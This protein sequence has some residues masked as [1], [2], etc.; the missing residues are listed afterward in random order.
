MSRVLS[1]DNL[2]NTKHKKFGFQGEWGEILGDLPTSSIWLIQGKEKH[3][4]TALALSLTAYLSEYARSLY[5]SGEEGTGSLF[6]DN[7]KRAGLGLHHKRIGFLRYTPINELNSTLKKRYSA[8]S[9]MV[10]NM[11]VYDDEFKRGGVSRFIKAN[12]NKTLIFICHEDRNEPSTAAGKLVKKLADVILR[13]EGLTVT[14]SGR[15][16]GGRIIIHEEKA[17]QYGIKN[18]EPWKHV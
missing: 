12:E 16:P 14:V 1:I 8:Q 3:G 17:D 6:V 10:D 13:V 9:V 7:C 15:C 11:T 5:V 4:K 18:F 2:Y